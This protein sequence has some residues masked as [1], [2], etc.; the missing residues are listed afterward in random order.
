MDRFM[1]KVIVGYP[2]RDEEIQIL[3][4]MSRT[5]PVLDV[6]PTMAPEDILRARGLVDE[7]YVDDRVRDY[8]VDLVMATRDPGAYKLPIAELIQFG[9]SP[10]ATINLTL[11]AKANAF[12]DGRGYVVP[13]D[14]KDIAL[15]VLRHRVIITYEA[16]AEEKTSDDVV[17]SILDHV[18]V[19]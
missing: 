10:R 2:N 13:G 6:T 16:E 14:V 9:A 18:A 4:R 11:A 19:P 7:I 17:R 1:M 12:L 15:D 8:I 5:K 3:D